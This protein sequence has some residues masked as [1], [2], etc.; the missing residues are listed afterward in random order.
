MLVMLVHKWSQGARFETDYYVSYVWSQGQLQITLYIT[1]VSSHSS[2]Y[3]PLSDINRVNLLIAMLYFSYPRKHGKPAV[4][5][6][7]ITRQDSD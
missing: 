5:A 7:L 6:K 1:G 2:P 3:Q 4:P